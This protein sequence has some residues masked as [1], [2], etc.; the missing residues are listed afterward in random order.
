MF[1][2]PPPKFR[3]QNPAAKVIGCGVRA[4][5]DDEV[6]FLGGALTAG[7]SA[8]IKDAKGTCLLVHHG[9][10]VTRWRHL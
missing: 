7:I 10:D 6:C 1:V 8:L 2:S 4:C 3:C 9:E 5:G